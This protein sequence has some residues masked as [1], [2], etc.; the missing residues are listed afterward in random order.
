MATAAPLA[1][2]EGAETREGITPLEETFQKAAALFAGG[3][4]STEAFWDQVWS[5]CSPR[6]HKNGNVFDVWRSA[7]DTTPPQK[8]DLVAGF[9][10]DT[11]RGRETDVEDTD[12]SYSSEPA[13]R[14][15]A[16]AQIAASI[17]TAAVE[18]A[19]VPDA[20]DV[21]AS[22]TADAIAD[23][24]EPSEAAKL[25]AALTAAAIDDAMAPEDVSAVAAAI[26][27]EAIA[28][29][30]VPEPATLALATS[31]AARSLATGTELALRAAELARVP[32]VAASITAEA[33]ESALAPSA[34]E[35][36]AAAIAAEALEDALAPDAASV[37]AA[38][39]AEAIVFAS[40]LDA[41]EV[42]A[43]AAAARP[44]APPKEE[45]KGGCTI[46]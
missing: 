27:A 39:A 22:I 14:A 18:D 42:A 35:R 13:S 38:I 3:A 37:A 31:V 46:A 41:D 36:V 28:E 32:C 25:A 16:L 23:A 17:T 34:E 40:T 44:V 45:T 19:L 24:L 8:S 12:S 7:F 21:A 26:A 20:A 29:A 43:A 4:W 10:R 11:L 2:T 15:S 5:C 9:D 6:P 30:M 33:I 1:P